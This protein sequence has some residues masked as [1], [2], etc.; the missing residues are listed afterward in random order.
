MANDFEAA[1][2]FS[3]ALAKLAGLRRFS[4][5][6]GLF[7]QSYIDALVAVTGAR[8]G[9]VARRRE[10]DTPGW[11]KVVAS[12]ANLGGDSLKTFLS[13]V[14][15]LCDNSLEKGEAKKEISP[16]KNGAPQEIG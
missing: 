5:P 16:A 3:D 11:R 13:A 4:G 12:P 9:L 14:E 2:R 10:G 8:F 6:P 7:W 1:D 15:A